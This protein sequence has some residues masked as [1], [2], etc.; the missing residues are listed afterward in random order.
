MLERA[1]ENTRRAPTLVIEARKKLQTKF[2]PSTVARGLS[3]IVTRAAPF[4]DAEVLPKGVTVQAMDGGTIAWCECLIARAYLDGEVLH[5][6]TKPIKKFSSRCAISSYASSR[7]RRLRRRDAPHHDSSARRSARSVWALID[8]ARSPIRTAW[9]S[10]STCSRK[11]AV[12]WA[13]TS[14]ADRPARSGRRRAAR[15]CRDSAHNHL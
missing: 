15:G 6:A 13:S 3:S 12:F 5:Q 4:V 2:S 1:F 8:A 7:C 10:P 11:S 9:H 14:S